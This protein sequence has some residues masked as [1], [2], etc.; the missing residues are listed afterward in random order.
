VTLYLEGLKAS[1][2][3]RALGWTEKRVQNMVYRGLEDL[4]ECLGPR[5]ADG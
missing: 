4:R 2:I 3:G 5:R 1:E